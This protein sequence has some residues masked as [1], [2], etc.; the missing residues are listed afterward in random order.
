VVGV[1]YRPGSQ[2]S[3]HSQASKKRNV[4][5]CACARLGQADRFLV[6][7]RGP[8]DGGDQQDRQISLTEKEKRCVAGFPGQAR[9]RARWSF[10]SRGGSWE[11]C[12]LLTESHGAGGRGGC[13][14]PLLY[15]LLRGNVESV[16]VILR[17]LLV[18]ISSW[19]D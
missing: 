4:C 11:R 1:S 8:S 2:A 19:F 3:I 17:A 10:I 6:W 13:C 9:K 18:L 16:E 7:P 5:V 12:P 15:A 14:D